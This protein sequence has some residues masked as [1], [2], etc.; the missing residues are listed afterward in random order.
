MKTIGNVIAALMLLCGSACWAQDHR[1]A[2][3][4]GDE[5]A[6]HYSWAD[7]LRVNPVY[8]DVGEAANEPATQRQECYDEQVPTAQ[9]QNDNRVSGTI[10]GGIIGGLIGNTFGRGNGRKATTAAGVVAGAAVGNSVAAQQGAEPGYRVER[11]C[12]MVDVQAQPQ[13]RIVAYDVEYRYRG[14]IY[15]SRIAYDPGDRMRVRVSV[16][17]AD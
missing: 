11:H 2:P 9:P 1:N 6:V 3:A 7:V 8:E 12:R 17:P 10:I 15:M 4:P 13:R 5:T 16:L 14:E